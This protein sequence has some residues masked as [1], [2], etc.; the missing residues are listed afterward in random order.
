MNACRF[1][2][3]QRA[4]AAGQF[5]FQATQIIDALYKLAGAKLLVFKQLKT[6]IASF[7]QTLPSQLQTGFIDQTL[8]H[9]DGAAALGKLVGHIHL[10]QCRNDGGTIAFVDVCKQHSVVLV[11]SSC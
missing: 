11:A 1:D 4:D 5:A 2:L 6:H 8:R 3:T 7:G 9:R 10:L